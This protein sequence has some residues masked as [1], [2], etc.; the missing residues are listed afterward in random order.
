MKD[1]IVDD[2]LI[3]IEIILKKLDTQYKIVEK[4]LSIRST[5]KEPKESA[6]AGIK[7]IL[8]IL[9]ASDLNTL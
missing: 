2:D 7:K 4:A 3:L 6:K 8:S 5:V 1:R 9:N